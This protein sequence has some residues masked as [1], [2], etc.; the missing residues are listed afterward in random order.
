MEYPL[1]TKTDESFDKQGS[2]KINAN[3]ISASHLH[4]YLITV[5]VVNNRLRC[6]S[7]LENS[8]SKFSCCGLVGSTGN[9]KSAAVKY[10]IPVPL[11]WKP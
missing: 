1:E 7:I 10:E 9:G 4:G 3:L 11:S 5:V 6:L 8:N 2:I